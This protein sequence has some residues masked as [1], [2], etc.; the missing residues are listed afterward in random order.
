VEAGSKG[1]TGFFVE[2]SVEEDLY[3]A[4]FPDVY[5]KEEVRVSPSN[6]TLGF[7]FM[8]NFI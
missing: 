8:D 4:S 1:V 2:G 5:V 3:N 7:F 6:I